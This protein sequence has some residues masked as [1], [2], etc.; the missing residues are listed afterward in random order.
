MLL[1]LHQACMVSSDEACQQHAR[2]FCEIVT[3]P[4]E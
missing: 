1:L 4:P 2:N 3:R